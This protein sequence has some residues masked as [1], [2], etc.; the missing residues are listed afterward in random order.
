M[1]DLSFSTNPNGAQQSPMNEADKDKNIVY[2]GYTAGDLATQLD[3]EKTI[4]DLPAYQQENAE[5]S[6]NNDDFGK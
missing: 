2:M 4:D 1:Q 3:V 5:M 6:N